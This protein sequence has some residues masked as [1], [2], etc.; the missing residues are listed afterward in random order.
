[1]LGGPCLTFG[2]SP[3]ALRVMAT[4]FHLPGSM[5][6]AG[7]L[8]SSPCALAPSDPYNAPPALK[9]GVRGRASQLEADGW[10]QAEALRHA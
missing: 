7:T 6:T 8:S 3:G 2:V 9:R 10:G 4:Y 1:M 5:D